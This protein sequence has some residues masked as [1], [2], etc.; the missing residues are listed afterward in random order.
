MSFTSLGL[1][2]PLLRAVSELGYTEPSP[3]QVQA[4]PAVLRGSDVLASAQTGTGKTASFVLPILQKIHDKPRAKGNRARVLIV[5]PTRELAAQVHESIVQYGRHL[6][7][8][9]T[10]VFGGVKINPQMMKLRGGVELLVAT[11]GR[12][13]DLHQQRAIQLDEIDTL[14]L[15]E[16]DR[17]LD[18]G[19]IHDIK[20]I[21]K[22]LPRNRQNLMFSATFSEEIRALVKGILN[23]P[24]EIDV[25]PR[26]TTAVAVKQT[27]HPVDKA[28]KS[29][30]LSHLIHKNKWGQT[31]VFSRT[32]HGANKLVKQLAE[33]HI[34]AAAIHG[35]K[36]QS[37]RT[38]ALADFKSGELHILVATDIAARGIDI[39]QLPCVVNFDL[40]QVAEDYVHRIGRTGRA[41]ASGQAI[42]LVSADEVGQLQ[43]I[44]KLIKRKLERVEI[45]DFEPNH[46]LPSSALPAKPKKNFPFKKKATPTARKTERKPFTKRSSSK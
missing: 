21:I 41:G 44:E 11:P 26:N 25:A 19:F 36:S 17:M 38:K 1:I 10:V 35:N 16:A 31:L 43:A 20:R 28:R 34:Y 23:Q 14:V 6:S 9:S 18:M 7:L 3:I 8:R 32:K 39:D 22:L 40:P 46:N 37:Q 33:E 13:L 2:E 30:L 4:I 29:A 5:T 45:E 27:V 24:V 15:D 12:L 42:S